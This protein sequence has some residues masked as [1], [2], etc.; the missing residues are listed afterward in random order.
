MVAE[1]APDELGLFPDR[2]RA[3]FRWWK[4][5]GRDPLAMGLEAWTS[6]AT[7]AVLGTVQ[8]VLVFV[9][10]EVKKGVEEEGASTIRAWIKR[11]FRRLG[12]AAAEE[13]PTVPWTEEQ[14]G[15]IHQHAYE[16]ALK[17]K[18]SPGRAGKL[19]DTIVARLVLRKADDG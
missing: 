14:L 8:S 12:P 16:E 19:A 5:R 6:I 2:C 10:A 7:F 1:V 13:P 11:G 3:Y 17:F 4:R 15:R 9:L 18:M